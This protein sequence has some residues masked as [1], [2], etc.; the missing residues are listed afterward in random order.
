M[1]PNCLMYG[2][3]FNDPKKAMCKMRHR[4][5]Q[6]FGYIQGLLAKTNLLQFPLNIDD[7]ING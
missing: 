4:Y 3:T 7:P 2:G 6:K 1:K 5:E